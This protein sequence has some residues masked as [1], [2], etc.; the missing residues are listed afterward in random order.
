MESYHTDS[1]ASRA[2]ERV[3]SVIAI[4]PPMRATGWVN[5]YALPLPAI[6]RLLD[7]IW[8]HGPKGTL[9]ETSN[10]DLALAVRCSAGLLPDLLGRLEA[11]GYITRLPHTRGTLVEVLR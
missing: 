5:P 3:Q 10:R 1:S 6:G 11:D 8:S 7:V 9:I 4:A 2:D